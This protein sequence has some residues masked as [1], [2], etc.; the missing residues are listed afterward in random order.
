MA[1][2]ATLSKLDD[3]VGENDLTISEIRLVLRN[4][5]DAP[6]KLHGNVINSVKAL[7]RIPASVQCDLIQ[8]DPRS[9]RA[10][11]ELL[12]VEAQDLLLSNVDDFCDDLVVAMRNV[13]KLKT[14]SDAMWKYLAKSVST[15]A[16][17]TVKVL[18]QRADCPIVFA[19]AAGLSK[20][21]FEKGQAKANVTRRVA[22]PKAAPVDDSDDDSEF[23][24][25]DEFD[26]P[27]AVAKAARTV[28][29]PR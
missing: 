13:A 28:K 29:R 17:R 20:S 11:G 19:K 24:L 23:D 12:S 21:E 2:K 3:L 18:S 5:D 9:T 25:D 14:L 8:C 26:D 6:K 16:A 1:T 4:W 10:I 27:K 15:M 22:R 7:D